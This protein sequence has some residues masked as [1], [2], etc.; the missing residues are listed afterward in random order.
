MNNKVILG[1]IAL[2][3]V[4]GGGYFAVKAMNNAPVPT[5]VIEQP[6]VQPTTSAVSPTTSSVMQEITVEGNEFAF[7]PSEIT[8]KQG[9]EVSLTF[10][11][12]G[13][14]PHNFVVAD[15]N[16]KTKTIQPGEEDTVTFTPDKTGS[17]TY[18]C[19]VPGHADKGMTG[20]LKVQ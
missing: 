10:K 17:F 2:I 6:T 4:L 5:P 1:I 9:Q 18:V 14:Y 15:L 16:I 8:V 13:R 11:N 7:T 20:T 3:V 12:K 19:A